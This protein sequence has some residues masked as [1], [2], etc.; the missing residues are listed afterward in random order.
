M[1][2]ICHYW[3]FY[4]KPYLGRNWTSGGKFNLVDGKINLNEADPGS[5]IP[6]IN[7]VTSSSAN[8]FKPFISYYLK[9]YEFSNNVGYH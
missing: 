3:P 7:D 5:K 4:L 1:T 2:K 8:I 6:F 9:K